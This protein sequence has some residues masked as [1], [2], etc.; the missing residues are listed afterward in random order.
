MVLYISKRSDYDIGSKTHLKALQEIYG[1][2][3][4]IVVD[5]RL[6][7]ANSR[8]EN[9]IAYGKYKKKISRILRWCQGNNMYMSNAI[10]RDI[11][12]VIVKNDV[13]I[14]F[15]EESFLG[16]LTKAIKKHCPD[17]KTIC[18]YHDIGADLFR[19]NKKR[20][21]G[22]LKIED[23]I[24]IKQ[25]K[26]NV[27]YCDYNLV[28]HK[29]DFQRFYNTYNKKPDG[30]I[31]LASFKND[32]ALNNCQVTSEASNKELFF[33]CSSYYPNIIGIRWFYKNVL[34]HLSTKLHVSVVGRGIDFLKNEFDHPSIDVVGYL[35]QLDHVYRDADIII[36]PIFDGGG[37]KVKAIEAVTNGK[38]IVGTSESLHGFWEEMASVKNSVVFQSDN[39][40]EWVSILNKLADSEIKKFNRDLYEIYV[41]Y[42]SYEAMKESF[43]KFFENL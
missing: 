42:F 29:T 8:T 6:T 10:I 17:T 5:L 3:N 33:V 31:P 21:K 40:E 25:E 9:Y 41:Q 34:P 2:K 28:F 24:N 12:D 23:Q 43:E 19:Q 16:N 13:S 30:M 7:V 36:L 14:V 35:E 18:F 1:E 11:I 20:S 37:M 22:L 26:V 32:S 38:C 15:S 39:A 27:K 4:V